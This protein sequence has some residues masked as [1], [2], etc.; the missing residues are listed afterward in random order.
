MS[1]CIPS[2]PALANIFLLVLFLSQSPNHH[3]PFHQTNEHPRLTGACDLAIMRQTSPPKTISPYR[4]K[5]SS[6]IPQM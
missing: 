1:S 4:M 2:Y 6:T 5:T 3:P